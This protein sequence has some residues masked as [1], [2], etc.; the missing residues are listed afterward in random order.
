MKPFSRLTKTIVTLS[1]AGAMAVLPVTFSA[2]ADV[3]MFPDVG[4]AMTN[5]DFW[6]YLDPE[7]DRV[8]MDQASIA[9]LNERMLHTPDCQMYDLKNM[10]LRDVRVTREQVLK[11]ANEELTGWMGGGYY[12][13]YGN[14][15]SAEFAAPIL[16]NIQGTYLDSPMLAYGIAVNRT[17]LRAY[18]TESI[19]TD[20]LGDLNFDYI[21]LSG[22]R[23]NEPVIIAGTSADGQYCKV[24][25]SNCDG[26]VR[27]S[28]VAVCKSRGEWLSAW[29]IPS[30]RVLVVTESRFT[31]EYSNT[32]PETSGRELTLGT[33]LEEADAGGFGDRITNR[34]AFHNYAAYLPVRLS[35]GSY[36]KK[37]VLI[38]Q[39]HGIHEGYL[40]LTRRNI[41][42]TAFSMLGDAY[43]W[44]GMLAAEDCSGYIRD[45]YRCFGLELPRNTTWQAASPAARADVTGWSDV[46]KCALLNALPA[47]STLF[48][49]GH[50]MMYL[51]QWNGKYYVISS[52]SS[53][54]NPYGGKNLRVR[55]VVINTLD[56]IRA[57]GT[58]W[59]SN[60][61]TMMIPYQG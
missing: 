12:D 6:A 29:D 13:Q 32:D 21:Q 17:D 36:A 30:E 60:L 25:T 8:Q 16:E 58:T 20:E 5:P 53:M 61:H 2:R 51:G 3:T 1:L 14:P 59:L 40:P 46:E 34:A 23:V 47:G 52:V 31:T 42:H 44:G 4:E 37:K 24:F 22:I 55:S 7:A 43:G 54:G 45:I 50:T 18:P 19:V 26:W 56:V 27:S 38:S 48:F 35:D 9:A 33:V 39:H 49:R 41:L 28:D 10:S 15:I 57:N 11:H